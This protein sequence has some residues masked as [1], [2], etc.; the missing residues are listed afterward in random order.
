MPIENLLTPEELADAKLADMDDDEREALNELADDEKDEGQDDVRAEAD[1]GDDDADD[2]KPEAK[3][4][5]SDDD[6]EKVDDAED[7]N[8]DD[9][10]KAEKDEDEDEDDRPDFERT[11]APTIDAGDPEATTESLKS[12]KSQIKELR[13]KWRDG[14]LDD[15]DYDDKL[16]ELE[17]KRDE[18][19]AALASAKT[20]S[21]ITQQTAKQAF[22]RDRENFLR[23]YDRYEGVPYLSNKTLARDFQD[24]LHA[25]ARAWVNEKPDATAQELFEAAHER[26]MANMASLGVTFGK[27]K[28]AEDPKARAE[29]AREKPKVEKPPVEEKPKEPRKVPKSLGGLPQAAPAT[30]IG[31]DLNAKLA[32]LDGEDLELF[33]AKLP[34][35]KRRALES[36]D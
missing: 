26:V 9:E 32:T 15:A 4:E 20:A 11:F 6:E 35:D 14:E 17:T 1:D 24:E 34:A 3:A 21:A 23:M 25:V 5:E 18:A 12:I 22:E 16:D 19:V 27:K 13:K 33:I 36:A 28:A 7:E 8:G 2:E 30:G 31:D 10:A 29:A